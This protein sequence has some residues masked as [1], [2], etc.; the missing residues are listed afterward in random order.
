LTLVEIWTSAESG[1]DIF[2]PER[3]SIL[4]LFIGGVFGFDV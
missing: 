3:D 2:S 4:E 1:M